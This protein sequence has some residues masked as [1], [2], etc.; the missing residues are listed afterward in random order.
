MT[1]AECRIARRKLGMSAEHVGR[2]LDVGGRTIKAAEEG[3]GA[4]IDGNFV[5]IDDAPEGQDNTPPAADKPAI[6]ACTPESFAKQTNEWKSA[7]AS[8][9]K[10]VKGLIDTIQTRETLNNDQQ[11]EIASWAV[12]TPG[13][14][15]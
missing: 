15:A 3:R 13:E 9:K 5:T 8:G 2:V 7:L 10:T 4:V 14:Q 6:P 11:M 1:P 12:V